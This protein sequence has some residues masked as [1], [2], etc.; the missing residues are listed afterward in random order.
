LYE[1]FH[2][3]LLDRP[4]N[5]GDQANLILVTGPCRTADTELTPTLGA[6]GPR[7]L[8]VLLPDA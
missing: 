6:H 7:H 8:H 1:T 4:V 2:H 3:Y 5:L